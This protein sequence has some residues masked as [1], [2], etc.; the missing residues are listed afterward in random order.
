MI[1]C[2][3][4]LFKDKGKISVKIYD[5]MRSERN[6]EFYNSLHLSI[7]RHIFFI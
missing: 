1:C 2:P 4:V 3:V 5:K 6:Y 7:R